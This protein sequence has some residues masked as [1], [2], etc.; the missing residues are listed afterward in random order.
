MTEPEEHRGIQGVQGVQ[1]IA[2]PQGVPGASTPE[3]IARAAELKV[4]LDENTAA[5]HEVK[6]RQ[7]ITSG[8]LIGLL[9]VSAVLAFLYWRLDDAQDDIKATQ[10]VACESGNNV[11]QGLLNVADALEE[12]GTTPRADGRPRTEA[13]IAANRKFVAGLRTDFALREC[14]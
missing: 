1:G 14:S 8:A 11:R 6:R 3:A 13:E 12:A 10:T 9:A 4:A 5:L 7:F 2:G